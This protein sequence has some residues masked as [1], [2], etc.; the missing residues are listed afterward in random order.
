MK[1]NQPTR[2]VFV[3]GA[4]AS[5]E[6]SLPS[7]EMLKRS[8]ASKLN[9]SMDDLGRYHGGD[10]EIRLALTLKSN[11]NP[12]FNNWIDSTSLISRAMPLASSIDNFLNIH[13]D[14]EVV[15]F[16][17]KAAIVKSIIEAEKASSL[18]YD[19]LSGD[20]K[21]IRFK[22]CENTWL[23]SFFKSVTTNCPVSE[24]HK[25]FKN[26]TFIIFNYDRCIEHFLLHAIMLYYNVDAETSANIL[27]HLQIYHPYG[28]V[29]SLP[30]IGATAHT[31][32]GATL[33]PNHIIRLST[34]INTFTE[35]SNKPDTELSDMR[36][37][38]SRANQIIFLGFAFHEIN[39]DLLY[40][41]EANIKNDFLPRIFATAVGQSPSDT[42][43]ITSMLSKRGRTQ[44]NMISIRND[45]KC[46]D[47]LNE[48]SRSIHFKIPPT[49]STA[50]YA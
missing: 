21:Q 10:S 11:E 47:L 36:E 24:L 44:K 1:P 31:E 42:E 2:S 34:N 19:P 20:G 35:G 12:T 27:S 43:E 38:L 5:C 6:F 22:N 7:G 45:K 9:F 46:N 17:G 37:I 25:R 50:Q 26:L 13:S 8:I 48:Y 39:M 3:I 40:T 4:G 16:A 30:Y 49:N 41:Y 33:E 29:G 28:T 14:N 18:Y 15:K 23:N 32:F